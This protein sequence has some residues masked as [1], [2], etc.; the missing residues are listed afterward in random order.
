MVAAWVAMGFDHRVPPRTRALAVGVPR[1]ARGGGLGHIGVHADGSSRH[2]R[3]VRSGTVHR[4]LPVQPAGGR[5]R[6]PRD[7]GR[8]WPDAVA[9]AAAAGRRWAGLDVDPSAGT[10]TRRRPGA[11]YDRAEPAAP[12][13]ARRHQPARGG[14]EFGDIA[15]QPVVCAARM[16]PP[17]ARRGVRVPRTRATVRTQLG[18]SVF[19]R[20][21]RL[22]ALDP[23]GLAHGRH[24]RP[25][26]RPSWPSPGQSPRAL[27]SEVM[28]CRSR[29]DP[30]RGVC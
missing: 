26:A 12:T 2:R 14:H 9:A 8:G 4:G 10:G 30:D 3:L 17:T 22:G 24:H 5:R 23:M 15:R 18:T 11:R 25:R 16:A 27:T 29:S 28:T 13:G 20:P 7:R 1:R 6:D 21:R 19:P